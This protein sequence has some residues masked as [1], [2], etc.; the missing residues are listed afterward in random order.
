MLHITKSIAKID[1][2]SSNKRII[3]FSTGIYFSIKNFNLF[4]FL[5]KSTVRSFILKQFPS[6]E[7]VIS[8]FNHLYHP[9]QFQLTYDQLQ[10]LTSNSLFI[11]F[12]NEINL[13][14]VMNHIGIRQFLNKLSTWTDIHQIQ[15]C[16]FS[17]KKTRR[18]QIK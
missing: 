17:V 7:P 3:Q 9:P 11:Q 5:L 1:A 2:I 10:C 4:N 15:E 14:Q 18:K 12:C 13:N 16:F 6:K 8:S